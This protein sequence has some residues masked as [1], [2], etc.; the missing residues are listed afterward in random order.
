MII[1]KL[2]HITKMAAMPIYGKKKPYKIFF[3]GTAEPIATKL[4]T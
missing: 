4:E 3:A 2:S 1:N